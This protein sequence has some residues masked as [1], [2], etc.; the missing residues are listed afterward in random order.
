MIERETEGRQRKR[1]MQTER[2]RDRGEKREWRMTDETER[3][4]ERHERET[5]ERERSGDEDLSIDVRSSTQACLVSQPCYRSYS[6]CHTYLSLF[7]FVEAEHEY[8]VQASHIH[9]PEL[10]RSR[11]VYDQDAL[12]PLLSPLHYHDHLVLL[13][14]NKML[15][16]LH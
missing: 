13:N 7:L 4:R 16:L 6:S 14:E 15:S 11:T 2:D 12:S 10:G 8:L 3:G 1:E 5:R 9:V